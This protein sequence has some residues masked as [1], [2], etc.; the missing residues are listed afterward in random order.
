M[1]EIRPISKIK[2]KGQINSLVFSI[3]ALGI[4]VIVYV[5]VVVIAQEL[6]DTQT[7]GTEAFVAANESLVGLGTFGGFIVILVLAVVAGVV[8]GIIFG[9]FGF[10][11]GRP[12]RR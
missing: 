9:A 3:L 4:A 2:K 11:L 10:T 7:A 8:I 12:G 1:Q 6:R 5:L